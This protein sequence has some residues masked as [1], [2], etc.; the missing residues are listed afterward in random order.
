MIPEKAKEAIIQRKEQERNYFSLSNILKEYKKDDEIGKAAHLISSANVDEKIFKE[1]VIFD[2]RNGDIWLDRSSLWTYREIIKGYIGNIAFNSLMHSV[3]KQ[4]EA[5]K[6]RN[7]II[8]MNRDKTSKELQAFIEANRFSD[9]LEDK[10][11]VEFAN[12]ELKSRKTSNKAF[13]S[14]QKGI[15]GAK[16]SFHQAKAKSEIKRLFED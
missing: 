13:Q 10:L 5:R 2:F 7:M 9:N 16:R 4:E 8:R 11:N 15:K 3:H 6:F 1:H 12:L 14:Y